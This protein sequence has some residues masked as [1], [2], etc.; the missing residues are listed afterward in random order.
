MKI[1]TP[2]LSFA[3]FLTILAGCTSTSTPDDAQQVSSTGAGTQDGYN[4]VATPG[5]TGSAGTYP[6]DRGNN[7]GGQA[8]GGQTGGQVGQVVGG[9]S[10]SLT[11][12]TVY[13]DFDSAEIRPESRSVVEAHARYLGSDPAAATV[14]EGHADERGTREYNIALG[15]RRGEA[16][17]RLMSA[18][19][20]SFQQ[21]RVL[22][23][24]EE[25]PS[26]L[27]HDETSYTRNRRVEITY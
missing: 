10:A 6:Y 13:F 18:Y 12:R 1:L 2:L 20:V 25:R 3:F 26:E 9:P 7:L 5:D 17:R 19:G 23:Y 24:G 27:G 4:S 14:L 8:L 15:E 21:I 22:S 16:V 11:D